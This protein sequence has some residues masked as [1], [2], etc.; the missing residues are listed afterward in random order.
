VNQERGGKEPGGQRDLGG[1][2][3]TGK[4]PRSESKR[5]ELKKEG[6]QAPDASI[7]PFKGGHDSPRLAGKIALGFREKPPSGHRHANDA[8]TIELAIGGPGHRTEG[9]TVESFPSSSEAKKR[10]MSTKQQTTTHDSRSKD[11]KRSRKCLL[12]VISFGQKKYPQ[13]WGAE[14]TQRQGGDANGS[15]LGFSSRQGGGIG[16]WDKRAAQLI[17]KSLGGGGTK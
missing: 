1:W 11:R 14:S 6:S 5:Q 2:V 9:P 15:G 10:V 4:R 17:R 7:L 13:K 3:F 8:K 12:R 16:P